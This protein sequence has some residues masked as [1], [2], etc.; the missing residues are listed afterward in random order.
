M[1]KV[2]SNIALFFVLL[3]SICALVLVFV[4]DVNNTDTLQIGYSTM[5]EETL[6]Q[7]LIKTVINSGYYLRGNDLYLMGD[8]EFGGNIR[9]PDDSHIFVTT[10]DGKKHALSV[11]SVK[12]I[13]ETYS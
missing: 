7:E 3:M 6:V 10:S 9:I 1:K 11:S 12:Y 4:E 13:L 5:D 8:I 2:I